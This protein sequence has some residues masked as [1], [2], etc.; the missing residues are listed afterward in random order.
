MGTRRFDS[1]RRFARMPLRGS[2][3]VVGITATVLA[4][5]LAGCSATGGVAPTP[6]STLSTISVEV[7]QNRTDVAARQL[8]VSVTNHSAATLVVE[9]LTFGSDQ[10]VAPAHWPKDR[11]AIAPGVTADLPVPLAATNCD[12]GSPPPQVDLLFRLDDGAA[13]RAMLDATDRL[14]QLAP[15]RDADCLLVSVAEIVDIVSSTAPTN[16]TT[17]AG[18]RT[19]RLDLTLT[20]TGAGTE[21]N[22][23]GVDTDADTDTDDGTVTISGVRST[24]LLT[25][26]P[27]GDPGI[28]GGVDDAA[29]TTSGE[30]PLTTSATD[31]PRVLSLEV[32]P[33]RCD[34]HAIAEDKRGTIIPLEMSVGDSAGDVFI[35]ASDAVREALYAF[36]REACA[37]QGASE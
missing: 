21:A 13:Q 2:A 35:A 29:A 24:T 19:A 17:P 14:G 6:T 16:F 31:A 10:F 28:G 9:E 4:A 30:L 15:L 34:A 26:T 32:R 20:P 22:T 18:T 5:T 33:S 1:A 37:A 23:N 3:F 12:G 11:T 36:V 8:Q 25:V 7:H 27:W